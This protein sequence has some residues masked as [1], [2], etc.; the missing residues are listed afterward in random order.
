MM[1]VPSRWFLKFNT[2]PN[3]F[4]RLFCFAPA[5]GGASA[6]RNWGQKFPSDI[7]VCAIQLPG[8]ETQSREPLVNHIDTLL[9]AL[10]PEILP[11]LD[12][13][14]AIFGH[15][16]GALVGYEFTRRLMA[17]YGPLPTSL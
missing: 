8:R 14:F 12:K 10:V 1:N 17:E 9:D 16:L 3:N 7:E 15:S 6:F 5:G 13:P 11:F 4:S 2:A